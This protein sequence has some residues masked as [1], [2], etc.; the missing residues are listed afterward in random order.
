MQRNRPI[1]I[2]RTE[3]DGHEH[4]HHGGGWKVA[5]ADFMTA[6]MAFFLIMWIITASDEKQLHSLAEYFTPSIVFA[7]GAGSGLLPDEAAEAEDKA[8]ADAE[9]R[10]G[11]PLSPSFGAESP[12][13]VF[14]SRLREQPATPQEEAAEQPAGTEDGQEQAAER[15]ERLT[16]IARDIFE[17]VAAQPRLADLAQNLRFA[18][19]EEGLQIEVVDDAGRS[20][21]PSGSAVM[22]ATTRALLSEIGAAIRALPYPIEVTGH[23]DAVPFSGGSRRDNW[24]LSADRANATRQALTRAGVDSGRFGRIS[25]LA[26]TQPLDPVR[27]EAPENRRIGILLRD[28]TKD[29]VAQGAPEAR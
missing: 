15:Q 11:Q 1:I 5:Y 21:F 7:D 4:H 12:L 17:A 13:R 9:G 24:A 16:E 14:D 25:G 2:R 20:M 22:E 3:E 18:V 6:M 19:T 10:E 27:P 26:A 23:T 8:P 28:G 29:A